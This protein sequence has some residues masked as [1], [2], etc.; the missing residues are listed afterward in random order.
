[1]TLPGASRRDA[2]SGAQNREF[3]IF[4]GAAFEEKPLWS[5]L[6]ESLRD[7]FFPPRLA[8]L[9]L[10]STLVPVPDRM[11]AKTNPWAIGTSTVLNG[12]I[13]ALVLYLGVQTGLHQPPKTGSGAPVDINDIRFLAALAAHVGQGSSGGGTGDIIAPIRGNPPKTEIH[14]I[15]PPQVSLI[16]H[17]KL[18]ADPAIAASEIKLPENPAL[19]TLGVRNSYNVTRASNGPGTRGGIGTGDD[20]GVGPGNRY[21]WGPG[22]DPGVGSGVYPPGRGVTKPVLVVAPEAEFSDEARRQKYQGICLVS[23][24][25]DTRGYPRNLRVVR[26]LGMGLDEKALEAIGKYRFKPGTKDGKPVATMITV[27]VDFRLF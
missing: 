15:T 11:A 2:K 7:A 25:V 24:I 13:L 17:P 4:P 22:F 10:T 19:P 3:G 5:E 6:Y 1:M 26:P 21:G 8:P 27:E 18:A 16:E 9:E 14:P 12:G 20:G 23:V